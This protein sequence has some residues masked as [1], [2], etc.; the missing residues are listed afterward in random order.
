MNY[1]IDGPR[2]NTSSLCMPILRA[3]PE[4][5]GIEEALLEYE[6]EIDTLPT[7]L[8]HAAETVVGFLSIKQHFPSTA[9]VFV[10]GVHPSHFRRG[11]GRMLM[12]KSCHWALSRSIEYLHV[13][14]LAPSRQSAEYAATRDF[15]QA[16]GF[17]PLE[18]F[19]RI[20]DENNPCLILVKKI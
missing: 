9:E 3:L 5:F 16:M 15:Y 4:W 20:W 18:E 19:K 13:K 10:M 14:T 1:I 17:S 12:E 2:L 8:A 11:I 6:R 7:F